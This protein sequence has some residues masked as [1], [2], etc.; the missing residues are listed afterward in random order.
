[1][2]A[3]IRDT[4]EVKVS[5]AMITYNHEPFIAQAIESVLMQQAHFAV[6]LV[7][8]EDC[9]TD[10]TREIVRSYGAR[11]PERIRLLLPEHNR[12][13]M[14]N[15]V[16]TMRACRGQ[17]IALCEGDDY[18]TYPLK[19]QKQVDFLEMNTECSLC[20][21]EAYDL[22]PDGHRTE[23]V[24]SRQPTIKPLY[25]IEDVLVG[26]FIPTASMVF[27]NGLVAGSHPDFLRVP[28]GDWMVHVMLAQKG[29]LAFLDENW[30]VRRIHPGG[31]TSMSTAEAMARHVMLS[32]NI[33]D[34][35]LR[36]SYT[37]LLRPTVLGS[38]VSI[39][40]EAACS[41]PTL[42]SAAIAIEQTL[43]HYVGELRITPHE[44]EDVRSEAEHRLVFRMW[45][46]GDMPATRYYWWRSLGAGYRPALRNRGYWSIGLDAN[47]GKKRISPLRYL[48]RRLR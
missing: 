30:S 32:A 22:W 39:I 35:Y 33:I 45:D 4:P 38:L 15:F 9:S 14:P 34:R 3:E 40:T 24:R 18:W 27:R 43:D 36:G 23:Y 37:H 41:S 31:M 44:R 12:G 1:M 7:I 46:R 13:A 10:R 11:Y 42:Q 26:H 29:A 20:F 19:L 25:S 21:H 6:E 8:G 47:L 2:N 5:V 28:A 48:W 16:A 17:Y